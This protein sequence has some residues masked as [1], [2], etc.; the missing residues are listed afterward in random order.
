MTVG[1]AVPACPSCGSTDAVRM[2]YGY[3]TAETFEA[4]ERGEVQLGGCV[5]G[6][7]SPDYAC[8]GCGNP[9]PWLARD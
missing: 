6:E 4:A 5:I 2:V 1:A 9:L 8:Q 7:E 3:P